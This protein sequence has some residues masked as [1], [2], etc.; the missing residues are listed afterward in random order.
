MKES[1]SGNTRGLIFGTLAVSLL[2]GPAFAQKPA[3]IDPKAQEMLKQS[4]AAYTALHSY[5]CQAVMELKV[6][7]LP[8]REATHVKV[9]LQRPNQAAVTLSQ[10]GKT[11]E[12]FTE[13]KSLYIYSSDKKQFMQE[14]NRMPSDQPKT[15]PVI[16]RG[17]SFVALVLLEPTVLTSFAS[18]VDTKSL[19]LGPVSMMSGIAVRTLTK[20]A[21]RLTSGRTLYRL[22]TGVKN[23]LVY[24]YDYIIENPKDPA[25]GVSAPIEIDNTETYTN[26]QA[27]PVL[28]NAMFLPPAGAKKI[29]NTETK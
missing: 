26:I 9:A 2:S 25:M 12:Y 22:T 24:R 13:G 14:E 8:G 18:A 20:E 29:T 3:A 4:A 7:T 15:A 11:V 1:L 28:P 27:N 17:A 5:S 6:D 16:N 21:K 10:N 23:H 19:T